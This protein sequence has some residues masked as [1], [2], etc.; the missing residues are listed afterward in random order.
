[1]ACKI[2]LWLHTNAWGVYYRVSDCLDEDHGQLQVKRH[3]RML[4]E[5]AI[6]VPVLE[7]EPIVAPL[8]LQHDKSARLGMPAHITLL[9]PFHPPHM[10]EGEIKDLT[11]VFSTIPA[12][13]FSLIE[14]RC[15]PRTAYLHP[16]KPELFI[17]IVGRLLE[18]WPDCPPYKG[19][20][21]E[22]I[23]HLTVA[24]RAS[25][26]TLDM[27]QRQ[28]INHLPIT[29]AARE[30]R[31]IFSDNIG[32]WSTKAHLPLGLAEEKEQCHI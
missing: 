19:A 16:N 3:L 30:A 15:F 28:L 6:I 29:C 22:I 10:A 20:F 14:V 5:S 31:L 32:L 23:P 1:M 4:R 12:F 8:R 26:D 2:E 27:V 18:K 25:A 9:Y 13:E 21:A 7:A 17:G 11:E 24:D